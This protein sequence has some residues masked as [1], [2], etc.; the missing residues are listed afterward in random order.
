MA[1]KLTRD[2][3]IDKVKNAYSQIQK[4]QKEREGISLH[5]YTFYKDINENNRRIN[6][7]KKQ[8]EHIKIYSNSGYCKGSGSDKWKWVAGLNKLEQMACK[9]GFSVYVD[10]HTN[11]AGID[12]KLVTHSSYGYNHKQIAENINMD[13]VYYIK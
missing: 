1:T 2:Q 8:N 13:E 4:I 9:A 10:S 3:V 6:E 5:P 11:Y 12:S 7:V